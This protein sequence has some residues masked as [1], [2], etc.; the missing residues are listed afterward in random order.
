MCVNVVAVGQ[1]TLA[2][3]VEA[4]EERAVLYIVISPFQFVLTA[5]VIVLAVDEEA[6]GEVNTRILRHGADESATAVGL[7]CAVRVVDESVEHT[8]RDLAFLTVGRVVYVAHDTTDSGIVADGAADLGTHVA[9]SD[10]EVAL[11]TAYQTA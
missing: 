11:G 4:M 2:L 1:R 5:V 8:A 9:V 7:A 6:V 10:G 3:V